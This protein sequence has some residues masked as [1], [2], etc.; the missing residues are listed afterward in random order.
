[1]VGY[2]NYEKLMGYNGPIRRKNRRAPALNCDEDFILLVPVE[3]EVSLQSANSVVEYPPKINMKNEVKR[4]IF[5][6]LFASP[7]SLIPVVGGLT[8]AI[9]GWMI[10]SVTLAATGLLAAVA[11]VGIFATRLVWGLD[12][13]VDEAH[14]KVLQQTID[15]KNKALDAL[16]V[17]LKQDRDPRPEKCLAELRSVQQLLQEEQKAGASWV[18]PVLDD[19]ERLF[20]ICVKQIQKTDELWRAYRTMNGAAGKALKQERDRIVEEIEHTTVHLVNTIGNLQSS[21]ERESDSE[22]SEARKELERTIEVAK[23][24]D[25]RLA[26]IGNKSYD[27]KEFE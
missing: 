25:Q 6:D 22:L 5:I 4:K 16:E 21:T 8:G 7:V 18:G 20:E 14:A 3:D 26:E 27:P 2:L 11:G 12:A 15:E 19:F 17:R 9:F 13:I 23:R 24:V 1:M 10:G